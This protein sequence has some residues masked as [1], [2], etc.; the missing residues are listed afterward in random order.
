MH[1][2]ISCNVVASHSILVCPP[3]KV[4]SMVTSLGTNGGK[5]CF[6]E[7]PRTE[8]ETRNTI[9]MLCGHASDDLA[10]AAISGIHKKG[11]V[12]KMPPLTLFNIIKY[13]IIYIYIYICCQHCNQHECLHA[14][15]SQQRCCGDAITSRYTWQHASNPRPPSHFNIKPSLCNSA[16]IVGLR[17]ASCN[18]TRMTPNA[19]CP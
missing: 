13:N 14:G 16:S 19:D 17:L 9:I 18:I 6:C 3:S 2:C 7:Y 11:G 4:K 5:A 10:G 8:P 15:Y 1:A 12:T